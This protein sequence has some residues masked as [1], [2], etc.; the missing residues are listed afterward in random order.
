MRYAWVFFEEYF[1]NSNI[2]KKALIRQVIRN[3]RSWDLKTNESVDFF[4]GISDNIKQRISAFYGRDAAVIYPPVE[5]KKFSL[6]RRDDNFYLAVSA[7][8]PYKR[9]DIA[10]SAFNQLGKKLVIVGSGNEE[11]HLKKLGGKN[12]EFLGWVEDEGLRDYYER[13]RAL[14]FPG[15]EDFGIV[16][17]EAQA[18]GKPVIAYAKGG[19]L[20]TVTKD[21]GVFFSTQTPRALMEAVKYFESKKDTFNPQLLRENALR[22]DREIFKNKISSF[23]QEKINVKKA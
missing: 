18:C 22:F 19:V 11:R 5:T 12:I 3:L 23:I 10:I 17:L 7:L 1:G 21:T 9:I 20:E 16:P 13:C 6:S 15:E 4:I 8:V 14:V 2:L